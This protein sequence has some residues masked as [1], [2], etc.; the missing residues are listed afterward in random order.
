MSKRLFVLRF[1]FF[2]LCTCALFLFLHVRSTVSALL[3]ALALFEG[4]A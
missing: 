4:L 1:F 2:S 3:C